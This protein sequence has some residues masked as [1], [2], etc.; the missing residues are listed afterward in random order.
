MHQYH[1]NYYYNHYSSYN[2]RFNTIDPRLSDEIADMQKSAGFICAVGMPSACIK[3][4]KYLD[5]VPYKGSTY[6]FMDVCQNR[7]L[8]V[9][10]ADLDEYKPAE[11]DPPGQV[12]LSFLIVKAELY[13]CLERMKSRQK[14][15]DNIM[16]V[17]DKSNSET[18][19]AISNAKSFTSMKSDY[20]FTQVAKVG[21]PSV[22]Y[23]TIP[24]IK[25]K[26]GET[27]CDNI[28]LA[29]WQWT[30]FDFK[31]QVCGNIHLGIEGK[32]DLNKD[33]EGKSRSFSLSIGPISLAIQYSIKED[34]PT[35]FGEVV[36]V[37]KPTIQVC[38]DAWSLAGFTKLKSLANYGKIRRF[39]KI[40]L[41]IMRTG[42]DLAKLQKT[43]DLATSKCESKLY[44][45]SDLILN[46]PT[47]LHGML[48]Y[49]HLIMSGVHSI[50]KEIISSD[51]L[52]SN[53][54]SKFKNGNNRLNP[55]N[56]QMA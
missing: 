35:I 5:K 14:M 55:N 31:L 44:T 15:V 1:Q 56:N 25:G 29:S 12:V 40:M 20:S 45:Y 30:N 18:E 26:I 34:S 2:N 49:N 4:G 36:H 53:K 50:M 16:I 52:A 7:K 47:P 41:G 54:K 32:L 22:G 28:G 17:I 43:F 33:Y 6:S 42:K 27:I 9:S 21:L 23:D 8:W 13:D 51:S 39:F 38:W 46:R 3:G 10:D 24:S 19:T 11:S 37:D 48:V